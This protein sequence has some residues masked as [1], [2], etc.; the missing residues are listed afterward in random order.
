MLG[1]VAA[2]KFN[3]MLFAL[4]PNPQIQP[5]RQRIDHRNAHAVQTAGNL[6]G[7]VVEFAAGV[8]L[9]HNDFSRRNAFFLVHA[10]RNAAAV[11]ADGGRTVRVQ[12]NFGL[13]AVTGQS[14]V[15]RVVEHF[16][17][18]VV[19]TRTVVGVADVHARAFANRVQSLQNLNG[20]SVIFGFFFLN[21]F[22]GHFT[23]YN[24]LNFVY[25]KLTES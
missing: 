19:Q 11:V 3:Q 4:A 18:H 17:N 10:H 16:I 12:D 13:V 14:F 22:C 7:V 15:N 9:G 20:I 5:V 6:I 8:Q 23:H 2:G 1:H 24:I 25:F 21:F